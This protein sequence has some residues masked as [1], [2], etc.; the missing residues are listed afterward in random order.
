MNEMFRFAIFGK[1]FQ[2]K[3]QVDDLHANYSQVDYLC[4]GEQEK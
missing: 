3:S 2:A 4:Y 1:P